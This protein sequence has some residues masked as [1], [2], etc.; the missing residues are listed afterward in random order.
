VISTA[1]AAMLVVLVIVATQARTAQVR[2]RGDQ[3]PAG[4]HR[5]RYRVWAGMGLWVGATAID[6]ALTSSAPSW[7]AH[8]NAGALSLIGFVAAFAWSMFDPGRS[9]R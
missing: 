4:A 6:V 7:W 8:E 3:P 5:L 9:G 1:A 2:P